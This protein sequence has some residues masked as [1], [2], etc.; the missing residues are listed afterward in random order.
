MAIR[1]FVDSTSYLPKQYIKEN[2]IGILSL[3]VNFEDESIL[4]TEADYTYFYEKL[5]RVQKLPTSSQ[6]NIQM[7]EDEF[8]KALDQG[9]DIFFVTLS[10]EMSGTYQ[11]AKM[12]ATELMESYPGQFI[13][14]VDS[15][16]NCMQ[17]GLAAMAA[18]DAILSGKDRLE[19]IDAIEATKKRTRFL[20]TLETLEFLE[21]GGRVGKA[22]ALL[23]TLLNI[24]PILTVDEGKTDSVT[25]V[26][27]KK[28]AIKSI[29]EFLIADAKEYGIKHAYIHHIQNE[30]GV[31]LLKELLEDVVSI[32]TVTEIGPVIGTHVGPGAI[33][34]VYE[35]QNELR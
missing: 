5:A 15:E 14:V 33:G 19:I 26:R 23:G 9:Y 32:D 28:K 8:R 21:K 6:P 30:E 35:T 1:L 4:E 20:F 24:K 7:I 22:S 31:S 16:S 12:V 27:T 29:A 3:S 17:L 10:A 25:K 13:E 11:T 18:N 2:N 34:V